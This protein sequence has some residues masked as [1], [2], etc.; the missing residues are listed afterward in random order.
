[1]YRVFD[2]KVFWCRRCLVQSCLVKKVFGVEGFWC[3]SCL[4]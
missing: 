3:K 4:V 1:M 2:F